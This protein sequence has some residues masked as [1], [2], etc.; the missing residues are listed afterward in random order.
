MD[1]DLDRR[2]YLIDSETTLRREVPAY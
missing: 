2:V 1:L